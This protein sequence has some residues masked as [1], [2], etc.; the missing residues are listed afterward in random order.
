MTRSATSRP[1]SLRFCAVVLVSL[2]SC[3]LTGRG[4]TQAEPASRGLVRQTIPPAQ[5]LLEEPQPVVRGQAP[6]D[7]D[8]RYDVRSGGATRPTYLP[9]YR[10]PS[11]SSSPSPTAWPSPAPVRLGAP[12][13]ESPPPGAQLGQ[14]VVAPA[15]SGGLPR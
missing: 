4:D 10:S 12:Q 7:R 8:D 2:S 6:G 14:P 15:S 5:P 13:Y 3:V 1:V 11:V 9:D